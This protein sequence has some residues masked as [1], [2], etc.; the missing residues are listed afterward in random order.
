MLCR[1]GSKWRAR[2]EESARSNKA[3]HNAKNQKLTLQTDEQNET[4]AYRQK[5]TNDSDIHQTSKRSGISPSKMGAIRLQSLFQS[6]HTK[7]ASSKLLNGLIIS[8][9]S[10]CIK[11]KSRQKLDSNL[12]TQMLILKLCKIDSQPNDVM[13]AGGDARDLRSKRFAHATPARVEHDDDESVRGGGGERRV[14]GWTACDG[15]G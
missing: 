3:R 11:P 9:H 4:H 6:L 2:D 13:K 5:Q 7:R 1:T 10:V 14:E 8:G 15:R 12:P